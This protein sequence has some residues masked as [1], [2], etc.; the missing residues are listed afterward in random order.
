MAEESVKYRRVI[1]NGE[2]ESVR[3]VIEESSSNKLLQV[4]EIKEAIVNA[5]EEV[6][7]VV[8][9]DLQIEE[10]PGRLSISP[11]RQ[12]AERKPPREKKKPSKQQS[13]SPE[14]RLIES[15]LL[16]KRLPTKQHS[17]EEMNEAIEWLEE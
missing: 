10:R 7:A 6:K 1:N 12:D 13:K 3:V 16:S 14:Q 8:N 9:E 2:A 5:N 4:E 15:N 17:R 11:E